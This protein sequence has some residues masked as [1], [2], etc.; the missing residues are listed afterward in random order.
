[1][2]DYRKLN[3]VTVSD[4]YPLPE[5]NDLVTELAE[6]KFFYISDMYSGF[7]QIPCI[8][9][10][11]EKLAITAESGQFTWN[12]MPMGAKNCPAVFQ[13]L[14]DSV[15]R[16]IPRSQLV[17]YLDDLLVHAKTESQ[18]L[19]HL[20]EIFEILRHNNLKLRADKTELLA[21]RVT[22][23][24]FVIENDKKMPSPQKITA[25]QNLKIPKNKT[26]AQ[27]I[28][29]L[30]NYHRT[31]IPNFASKA[32]EITKTYRGDFQWTPQADL[33]LR[34]LKTEVATAA[35]ELNIPNMQ[36]ADFVLETDASNSGYGNFI[37][38]FQNKI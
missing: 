15:F 37:L 2:C 18:N 9:R 11:K 28:F 6:S 30:L 16:K 21:T 5:I 23:C 26:E 8:A 31:F 7:H 25:I 3:T 33:S 24:G 13:R 19:E 1:M 35:L 4:S 27:S 20:E 36:N 38:T 14:M 34:N 29:G 17:I 12:R 22:F 32:A 10:A